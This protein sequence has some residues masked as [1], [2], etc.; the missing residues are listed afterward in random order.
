MTVFGLVWINFL[1]VSIAKKYH[2]LRAY[3][4]R[5]YFSTWHHSWCKSFPNRFG[6][7]QSR[8]LSR[9]QM[10]SQS[11]GTWYRYKSALNSIYFFIGVLLM[12]CV[13]EIENTFFN[14]L[15]E[16]NFLPAFINSS[17]SFRWL[18]PDC[19]YGCRWYPQ[20]LC[21]SL[22]RRGVSFWLLRWFLPSAWF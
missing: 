4:A 9:P 5:G 15:G 16:I 20:S 11:E 12:E 19:H 7:T 21:F 10:Q 22:F 3:T 18:R 1:L 14:V 2:T 8:R 6:H 13:I 17:T